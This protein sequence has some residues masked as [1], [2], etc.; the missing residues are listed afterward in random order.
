M[1]NQ[2]PKPTFDVNAIMTNAHDGYRQEQADKAKLHQLNCMLEEAYKVQKRLK[3]QILN[4]DAELT[5]LQAQRDNDR[6]R[7]VKILLITVLVMT[8]LFITAVSF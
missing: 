2:Q 1:S 5:H 6:Q 8:V 4:L 7:F 3:N